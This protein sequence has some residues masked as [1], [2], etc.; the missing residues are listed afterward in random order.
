[1]GKKSQKKVTAASPVIKEVPTKKLSAQR[2]HELN[3]L[4]DALLKHGFN[5]TNNITEQWQQYVEIRSILDRIQTIENVLKPK[6][7]GPRNRPAAIDAF[8]KWADECGAQYNGVKIAEFPGYDMG[9]EA[10]KDFKKDEIF[11]TIPKKM[12]MS[13]ETLS[14]SLSPL[15][16]EIPMFD[17]MTHVK[18]AFALLL[19]KVNPNSFWKPYIDLL[20]EKYSTVMYFTVNEMQELKGS[21]ALSQALNQCKSIARQYAFVRKCL[22]NVRSDKYEKDT[23]GSATFDILK[24]KLTFELYCWAVSTVMTRQNA[25]PRSKPESGRTSNT[26]HLMPALIP[27]WDFTNHKDGDITS[28]YNL[29]LDQLESSALTDYAKA[30]QIFIFYGDRSNADLLVH[31]GFVYPPN[32][33]D[34]ISIRLGLSSSDEL[35]QQR[36]ELLEQLNIPK[37]CELKVLPAPEYISSQLL[38]FVRVFNMNRDQLNHWINS[39]RAIDLLHIDCALETVLESKTWLFLQTRLSLLLKVFPT[40]LDDDEIALAN[41]NKGQTKLG[42]TKAMLLQY[43]ILEKRILTNALDY[44]KQRTKA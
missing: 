8:Y 16:T 37:N 11:M 1:M 33:K 36:T 39:D 17:S 34:R 40:T 44:A 19:E 21:N 4:N 35:L 38:A 24:E 30:E 43:R 13:E 26:S 29:E 9:L 23:P 41:Y 3:N 31:N 25:I 32:S 14:I 12:I 5:Q 10:V 27:F 22:Q 2:R 42:H 28:S 18:L 20:P 7:V 15:V 6:G